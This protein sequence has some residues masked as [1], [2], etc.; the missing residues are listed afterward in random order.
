MNFD[1]ILLDI[2]IMIS[3]FNDQYLN[4][5]YDKFSQEQSQV[6]TALKNEAEEAKLFE[7]LYQQ[8]VH[9]LH[10]ILM[11]LIK[12]RN[13]KSKIEEKKNNM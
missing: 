13:L 2:S 10:R 3:E 12:L 4:T 6:M 11:D 8:Q 1:F 9:I 7:K 5:T